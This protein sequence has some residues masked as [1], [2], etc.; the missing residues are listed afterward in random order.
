MSLRQRQP[1]EED[2]AWLAIVRKMPCLI[3]GRPGPNDPAHLRSAARQYNKPHTGMG[4]KPSDRW[5][6]PLCRDHHEDQHRGN[7][8]AWW[9]RHGFPDPFA[10]AVALYASRP[11][12]TRPRRQSRVKSAKSRLPKSERQAIPHRKTEWPTRPLRTR[13]NLRKAT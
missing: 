8:L 4:E 6:L 12:Q 10:V 9:V 5:V 7:E 13:N 3:C 1:R 2:P 11:V